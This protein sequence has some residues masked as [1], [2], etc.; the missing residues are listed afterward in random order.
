MTTAEA[1]EAITDAGKFERLTTQVLRHL[2]PDSRL[3]EHAGVNAQG[4]TIPNPVDSFH[5]VPG[6]EPPRFIMHQFATTDRKKLE[7][8]WLHRP[9]KSADEAGDL[10]KA[11]RLAQKLREQFPSAQFIVWLC[12][13][14]RLD[15]DLMERVYADAAQE[16]L[17][18][19]PF[20]Q[21]NLRDWLDQDPEGH[22]LRRQFL[23]ITAER[24][25][26]SWLVELAAEN[27]QNYAGEFP[28]VAPADFVATRGAK[29]L[30][31]YSETNAKSL[32]LVLGRSGCGKSSACYQLLAHSEKSGRVAIWL[33][34]EIV[35]QAHTL[36]EAIGILLRALAPEIEPS[37]GEHALRFFSAEEPLVIV[38]D[39]INRA[40]QPTKLLQKIM[41][42]LHPQPGNYLGV[43]WRIICPIWDEHFADSRNRLKGVEWLVERS[44][45]SLTLPEAETCL[46]AALGTASASLT[47]LQCRELAEKLGRDPILLSMYGRRFASRNSSTPTGINDIIGDYVT[48]ACADAAKQ[49]DFLPG[50][51]AQSLGEL[52]KWMLVSRKYY[53]PWKFL[54]DTTTGLAAS[55]PAL[56]ALV[57]QGKLCRIASRAG[58]SRFEFR[59]DRLLA[60]HLVLV[61]A[62]F[63]NEPERHSAVLA[64]PF[65]VEHV[66]TGFARSAFPRTALMWLKNHAPVALFAAVGEFD[67]MNRTRELAVIEQARAWL[68]DAFRVKLTPWSQIHAAL[69][70][71]EQ[72]DTD[73]VLTITLDVTD[74]FG[75]ELPRLLRGDIFPAIRWL[76]HRHHASPEIR[77][78]WLESRIERA[79]ERHGP[80]IALALR[81]TLLDPELNGQSLLGALSLAALL[82][83]HSCAPEILS[84]ARPSA[85]DVE[86]LSWGFWA[87]LRC[88]ADDP[89][90]F[91]DPFL[92]AWRNLPTESTEHGVSPRQD[93]GDAFRMMDWSTIE[94]SV[95]KHL[96]GFAH[97]NSDML[98]NFAWLLHETDDPSAVVLVNTGLAELARK[99]NVGWHHWE[100]SFR[101]VWDTTR[102]RGRQMSP[103]SRAALRQIWEGAVEDAAEVRAAMKTWVQS[104]NDPAEL[105]QVPQRH[106]DYSIAQWRRGLL[107]DKTVT[108][109]MV[110]AVRRTPHWVRIIP[111]I[112]SPLFEPVVEEM[113]SKLSASTPADYSGGR[114]NE[115]YDLSGVLRDIPKTVAEPI[116]LRHW[117]RLHYSPLFVQLA[118]YLGS[119]ASMPLGDKAV[120]DCSNPKLL[121]EHCGSKFG[122]R[123]SG[124][125][126]RIDF[127]LLQRIAP[128]AA[129]L[130]DMDLDG[131]IHCAIRLGEREWAER[132]FQIECERRERGRKDEGTEKWRN[133]RLERFPTN[134]ELLAELDAM[135]AKSDNSFALQFWLRR[136]EER[137]GN[138]DRGW[139]VCEQWFAQS[140]TV[141]KWTFVADAVARL[142]NRDQLAAFR[143]WR[144]DVSNSELQHIEAGVDFEVRKRSPD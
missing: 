16:A 30:I 86:H 51:L 53:P 10:I 44:M 22:W 125:Q 114:T 95:I 94:S 136:L 68:R 80:A 1:L 9:S 8:K 64:E 97:E 112:W 24:L 65:F 15:P 102:S 100:M 128:Y 121:F 25:S 59:H 50:E 139:E 92:V 101:E 57:R 120:A 73:D 72:S 77:N 19:R 91:L 138:R 2:D 11:S 45:P 54:T 108:Q 132:E 29:E 123:T 67:G 85:N 131:L 55:L 144:P 83:D 56:R 32:I 39:D 115:H 127:G 78:S 143:R 28:L 18:V 141:A 37:A 134:T 133:I 27:L 20:G 5:R 107:G 34:A 21:S 98:L 46:R 43:R 3:I 84:A 109:E 41:N 70:L 87:A 7:G 79:R 117:E 113:L 66:G 130:S 75:V 61:L 82:G 142:G 71:L 137:V 126:E 119:A 4:K 118:V 12:T 81:S 99:S 89:A 104:T 69:R 35:E 48:D 36:P 90:R 58:E 111:H 6:S 17:E 60:H 140:R 110:D 40:Q 103:Q 124:L 47:S 76:V 93:F 122:F 74:E 63:I 116:L 129:F 42:W 38:V 26:R 135:G 23:G 31:E 96:V 62:Q 33:S 106:P 88:G 105:R 13:N 49:S 14:Q 52:A